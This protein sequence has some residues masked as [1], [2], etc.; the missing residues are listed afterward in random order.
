MRTLVATKAPNGAKPDTR[1]DATNPVVA[2]FFDEPT[3]TAT[4]IVREP[5]G[6]AA[7]IVD[8][9]L[10]FDPAAGRISTKS[11]D[12]L[13]AYVQERGLKVVWILETHAH[14]D[15]LSAAAYLRR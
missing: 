3:F 8:P 10:D 2:T 12:A 4:H 1:K 9:V 15:H 7:A 6:P 14:A 13:V 11:A 5:A